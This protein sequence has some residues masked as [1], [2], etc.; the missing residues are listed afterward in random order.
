MTREQER[1]L[2]LSLGALLNVVLE[3]EYLD[4]GLELG[5]A[6]ASSFKSLVESQPYSLSHTLPAVS[7][8][9]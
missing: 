3:Y 4:A 8:T 1:A 2:L 5:S 9:Q 7:C 6:E